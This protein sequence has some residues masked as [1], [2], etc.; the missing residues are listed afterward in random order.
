MDPMLDLSFIQPEEGAHQFNDL[1]AKVN[2]TPDDYVTWGNLIQAL[3]EFD[4]GLT[5]NS[6]PNILN[7]YRITND[8]FLA[9]FPL[10]F[11]YFT[12]WATTEF[13]VAGTEAA[14][15]VRKRFPQSVATGTHRT[16]RC[17]NVESARCHTLLN[18]GVPTSITR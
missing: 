17:S 15:T 12:Q 14:D 4:G 9:K 6:A 13:L 7:A 18:S 10:F 5:R 16:R 11:A 3:R 2:A 1:A 8:K